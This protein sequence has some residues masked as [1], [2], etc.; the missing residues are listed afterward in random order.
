MQGDHRVCVDSREHWPN[1][2]LW[3]KK[4]EKTSPTPTARGNLLD[5]FVE[6]DMPIT[7]RLSL[8]HPGA[9]IVR[10][11]WPMPGCQTR[12]YKTCSYDDFFARLLSTYCTEGLMA[13]SVR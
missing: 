6:D 1:A 12:C 11:A 7:R 5:L 3:T 2:L 9:A 13:L 8:P 10:M 4:T